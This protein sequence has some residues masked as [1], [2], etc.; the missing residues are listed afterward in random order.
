MNGHAKVGEPFG[1]ARI[2]AWININSIEGD[3]VAQIK[4]VGKTWLK[5][6]I[7]VRDI[8]QISVDES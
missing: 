8:R 3:G 7:S 4:R 1:T 2:L 6:G 5:A